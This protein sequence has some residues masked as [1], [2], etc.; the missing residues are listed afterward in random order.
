VKLTI[1]H[2]PNWLIVGGLGLSLIV[3]GNH[4]VG[5]EDV[6]L[7]VTLE[8]SGDVDTAAELVDWQNTLFEAAAPTEVAFYQRGTTEGRRQLLAGQTQFALSGVPFSTAELAARPEGAGAIISAPVAISSLSIVV[9]TPDGSGWATERLICDPDDPEVDGQACYVRGTLSGPIRMPAE[10]LGALAI[11]LSPTYQQNN[12][13][14]WESPGMQAALGTGELL[15]QSRAKRHTF[16]SRTEGSSANKYLQQY[17]SVLAPT[18]WSLRKQENP[19]FNWDALGEQMSSRNV[20][21][22]GADTQMGIIAIANVDAATNATPDTWSG[23]MGAVPTN[24]V[25]RL[26]RDYPA[27]GIRTVE[28]QNANGDWVTATPEAV[29]AALAAGSDPLEG[30]TAAVPGAYPFVWT[31]RL[32]TVAGTLTPDQANSMAALIRYVATDGQELAVRDGG[33]AITAEMRAEALAAADAVVTSNCTAEGYEVTRG[34]PKP[35]EAKTPQVQALTNVAACTKIP[36]PPET[37]TTSTT[38]TTVVTSTTIATSPSTPFTPATFTPFNPPVFNDG[39]SDSGGEST[40]D[41]GE[42]S[43]DESS[44]TVVSDSSVLVASSPPSGAPD[45]AASGGGG[46]RVQGV[47]LSALPMPVPD[48]GRG[49]YQKLGTL[50]V[51][52][53]LFLGLRRFVAARRLHATA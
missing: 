48:D 12:L 38:T 31:T 28:V 23:N 45:D 36:P 46:R 39:F 33:V 40:F 13:A 30:V 9:T 35:T 41:P 37:T 3:V 25:A 22:F 8:G 53:S 21:R 2:L 52:A 17:A 29:A 49:T 19:Q 34:A 6:V 1:P 11:G 24:Q 42:L 5:A 27:A 15:I 26:Q 44:T 43:A 7:P 51:G 50:L 16:V 20:S 4:R 47:P 10:T 32:Y 18:A 14:L